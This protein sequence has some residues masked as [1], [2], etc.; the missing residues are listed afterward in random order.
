[1]IT[2]TTGRA[3]F[4]FAALAGLA[5][6]APVL[7]SGRDSLTEACE[8]EVALSAAPKRLRENA[9][10]YALVNGDYRLL[11][12]GDGPL[13]CI[14][15]R[16]HR[17]SLVPQC[18]DRAGV[19]SVLPAILARSRMALSGA[20]FEEIDAE[21]DA[22]LEA[23]DFKAPS[24][25]G[26]SY[27][28]SDYNYIFVPSAKRILKVPA[29]VMFYA[30]GVSNADIGGSFESTV[31]NIGTPV[32]FSEGPHGYMIVY[33]QYPADANGVAEACGGQLGEAPPRFDPFPRG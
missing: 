5:T 19:D 10:V 1:M 22:K 31:K 4:I 2:L 15:E 12:E 27:M 33:T 11:R 30:P 25:P 21:S 17:D 26:I 16:H 9:S 13:T 14:V 20:G 24:R 23:G 3:A 28:M 18:V 29:H 32:L 6:I 8:I 7:A